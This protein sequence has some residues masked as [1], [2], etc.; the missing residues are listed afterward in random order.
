MIYLYRV[1]QIIIMIPLM[2]VATL[3]ACLVV[4]LGSIM[5]GGRWW[6]YYPA[7]IWARVMAWLTFVKVTVR[8]RDN[9]SKRQS[10]IFVANHQGAYDIFAIYG[11][12]GHNF[13]WMMKASLRKIPFVGYTCER[14]GHIYVDRST[15][16]GIRKT[17]TAAE[18]QLK[19]GMSV[20][21]FPEGSRTRTGRMGAFKR[22]AFLLAQEFDLPVV[23]LTIDGA[24]RVMPRDSKLPRPGHIVITIHQPIEAVDGKHDIPQ[25]I[26]KSHRVIEASMK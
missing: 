25:L 9:I 23:P 17:M 4:S 13:K 19:D 10:Y 12:L 5:F 11:F 22:G 26:E 21:V 6:G 2:I 14:A 3:L 18:K 8:G 16:S 15:P 20:V 24:F 1:Y 7:M